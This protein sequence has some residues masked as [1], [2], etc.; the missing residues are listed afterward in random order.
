MSHREPFLIL[1]LR[2]QARQTCPTR[3]TPWV[4]FRSLARWHCLRLLPFPLRRSSTRRRLLR[5]LAPLE[6]PRQGP[7]QPLLHVPISPWRSCPRGPKPFERLRTPLRPV[8][9][10]WPL[11]L[12]L[13]LPDPVRAWL[14]S[15]VR[16]QQRR[17]VWRLRMDWR[18]TRMQGRESRMESSRSSQRL[19]GPTIGDAAASAALPA[20][21]MR[22]KR[23]I[24]NLV[25]NGLSCDEKPHLHDRPKTCRSSSCVGLGPGPAATDPTSS[26]FAPR[27]RDSVPT[28]SG[29]RRTVQ[30]LL[31]LVRARP[32]A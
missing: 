13:R 7:Q 9:A 2:Q 24:S 8:W 30:V 25:S 3:A 29:H 1:G 22:D 12:K 17:R 15:R 4:P 20:L 16:V 27:Q 10:M 14:R 31:P 5:Q 26:R 6:Q 11:L 21:C 18:A 19:C 28:P 32:W 23:R